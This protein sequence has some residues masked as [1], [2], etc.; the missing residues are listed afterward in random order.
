MELSEILISINKIVIDVLGRN[1]IKL[2]FETTAKDIE[3][4]DSLNN[5]LII[6]SIEKHF[7]VK[8]ASQEIMHFRNV[9]DICESVK[10]RLK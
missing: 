1:T 6:V 5:L 2:G 4:W 9:G 8:F 10:L 3:D 7:K